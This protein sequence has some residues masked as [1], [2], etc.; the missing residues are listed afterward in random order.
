MSR[1]I[2]AMDAVMAMVPS[3]AAFIAKLATSTATVLPAEALRRFNKYRWAVP[4]AASMA[5]S[6]K[7]P[8]QVATQ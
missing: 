8:P 2:D 3:I 6:R 1:C 7:F 4:A 5:G